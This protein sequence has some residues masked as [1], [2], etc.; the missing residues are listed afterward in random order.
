MLNSNRK[1]KR[2]KLYLLD[3]YFLDGYFKSSRL[4]PKIMKQRRANLYTWRGVFEQ[5]LFDSMTTD[6]D[7]LN[8]HHVNTLVWNIEC[9][10]TELSAEHLFTLAEQCPVLFAK[11]DDI[12]ICKVLVY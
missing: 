5:V 4:I 8:A 3:E 7:Y 11:T 2:D 10:I 1:I 9:L 6:D 12:C